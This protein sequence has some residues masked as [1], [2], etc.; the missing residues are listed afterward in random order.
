VLTCSLV[1]RFIQAIVIGSH[2]AAQRS[3]DRSA[4]PG[5]SQKVAADLSKEYQLPG[6]LDVFVYGAA[7]ACVVLASTLV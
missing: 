5:R 2:L 7:Y 3:A 1:T 6:G 4:G